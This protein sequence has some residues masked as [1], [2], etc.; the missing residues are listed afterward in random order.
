MIKIEKG[1]PFAPN[2]RIASL[3][4]L[5]DMD[6]TDSFF[7]PEKTPAQ[8]NSAIQ[9]YRYRHAKQKKFAC[10]RENGGVRVWRIK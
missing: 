9:G 1:V 3:Y 6:V 7:V 4:P 5:A 8:M 10:V 2:T